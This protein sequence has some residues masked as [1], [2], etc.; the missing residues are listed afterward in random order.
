[1]KK[2]SAMSVLRTVG[3]SVRLIGRVD[4]KY[5]YIIAGTVIFTGLFPAL[6]LKVMQ[7]IINS[8]QSQIGNLNYIFALI[9]LYLLIG[10]VEVLINS[11]TGYYKTKFT[12]KFNIEMKK[13]VLNK[14]SRLS[15]QD[16]ESSETYDMMQRAENQTEGGIVTYFDTVMSIVGTLVTCVSYIIIVFSFRVWIVPFLIIIPIIRFIISN[17]INVEEFNMIKKRT[18]DERK[19]W[20]DGYIIT[21]GFNYKE[22]KL[23]DLFSHFIGKFESLSRH[24]AKQDLYISGKRIRFTL[25]FSI[26]EQA[27][28]GGLFAYTI[29]CGYLGNILIGDVITYTRAMVS[30]KDQIQSVIQTMA[31]LNKSG[32]FINQLFDFLELEEEEKGEGLKI[33]KIES[34]EVRSLSFKYKQGNEYVLKNINL[35]MKEG[36]FV[37]IVGRNGSGKSTLMKIL[38]GFYDEYEGEILVNGKNL[39]DIDKRNYTECIGALF[40]DFSKYEATIRENVCYSNLAVID[41]NHIIMEAC[42]NF[43]LETLISEQEKG[44]DTQ[45]GYWFEMGKELS[46]GQWQKIALARAFI[47][48]A[49]LYFLDE[50]NAALD[51]IS[52]Y[53]MAQ[54]YEKAFRNKIGVVI[55]H[56]FNHFIHNANK[57]IV[58]KEGEIDGT[59]DHEELIKS[60]SEYERLYMLQD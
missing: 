37:A 45:L 35:S 33:D 22:L 51:A 30:S 6:S 11:A 48:D 39:R 41:K 34:I 16:Y 19:A 14:A 20:Y 12:L 10:L 47:R 44:I 17:K 8:I 3:K 60:S 53:E 26:L 46:Y 31:D 36:D 54:L 56:K 43:G 52:E 21:C 59:G 13:E 32:M 25:L 40:Q 42:R 55:V 24:F 38:L 9:A 4:K 7:A 18:N 58:L 27:L 5:L 28:I 23:Y 2:S 57:I 1:M 50:P 49:D 15:L 29:Y